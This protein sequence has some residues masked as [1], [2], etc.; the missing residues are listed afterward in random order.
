M[1]IVTTGKGVTIHTRNCQTLE[2]FA[3]TPER[4]IDVGWEAPLPLA[5]GK[6]ATHTGRISA[7]AANQPNALA[8]LTNA[9]AK[10]EGA[11]TNLKI[12]NRQQD[13]FEIVLDVE[14]RDGQRRDAG[15]AGA[16]LT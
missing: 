4:F 3:A 8:S 10:Y 12:T 9:V 7:I 13:F 15:R 1:G 14:V 11:V 5:N 2:S 6:P 16:G